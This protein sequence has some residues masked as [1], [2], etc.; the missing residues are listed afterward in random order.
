MATSSTSTTDAAKDSWVPQFSNRPA[1]YREWR[2]RIHLYQKKM[3]IQKKPLEGV[4]NIVTNLTGIAWKQ[5]EP[6]AESISD[7]KDKGFERLIEALDRTFKYDERVEQPRAFEKFFYSLSR[8]G[9]QTLMSYCTEH[10]ECLR[11]V[12]KHDIRLPKEVTGWLLL[13][14]SGLT[15]EQKQ[16]V[17]SQC[18]PTLEED[19][20]EQ[21]MYYLFG[22]DYRGRVGYSHLQR[23]TGRGKGNSRWKK[24]QTAYTAYDLQENYDDQTEELYEAADEDYEPYEDEEYEGAY[25]EDDPMEE[26]GLYAAQEDDLPDMDDPEWEECYATYLDARRR[27]AELKTNRGFY[28]VVAL[29]DTNAAHGTSFQRPIPPK[30]KG[31]GSKSKSKPPPQK[32]DAKSRGKAA[33]TSMAK[34]GTCLRCG[35]LGHYAAQCPQTAKRS[36]TT[37]STSSSKKTKGETGM[38]VSI[39]MKDLTT[40]PTGLHGTLD[41]GA[42]CVVLGHET[43][44]HYIEHYH[45]LGFPIEHYHFRPA[46]KTLQFGGDRTLDHPPAHL[47]RRQPRQSSDLCGPWLNSTAHRKADPQ[48]PQDPPQLHR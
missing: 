32:G 28:P 42:S 16:L 11:E 43:L 22:Q 25:Y 4:I 23:P 37:T 31:K 6:I 45:Q 46:S 30:S 29:T 36:T 19:K 1:D 40:K 34:P 48:G 9:E 2:A 3:V 14:R 20:V 33:T 44:M 13:R 47:R 8:R 39:E 7:D 24:P 26:E 17:Q 10:R 5:I 15:Q 12:E 35:Q 38:M 41:G 18:G 27:F 21:A